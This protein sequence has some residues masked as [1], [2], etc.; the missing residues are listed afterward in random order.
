MATA[1]RPL[2]DRPTS[3]RINRMPSQ[4]GIRPLAMVASAAQNNAVTITGL[5]PS[6]SDIG[7]VI[8][9]PQASIAVATDR[10]RLLCA[11]LMENSWDSAGIIGCTQYNSAKVANPPENS[12]STVRMNIGVPFSMYASLSC[13]TTSSRAEG[14][15]CWASGATAGFTGDLGEESLPGLTIRKRI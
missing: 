10:I 14:E 7:P 15:V 3:A 9:R 13:A 12:A 4:L 2:K 11:A 5:R 1:A 6:L 8:S